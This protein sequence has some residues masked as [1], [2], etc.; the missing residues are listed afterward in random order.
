MM[1][2]TPFKSIFGMNN[3]L[4]G[5]PNDLTHTQIWDMSYGST[6]RC[7]TFEATNGPF[8]MDNLIAT[9]QTPKEQDS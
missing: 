6:T 1:I 5:I 8:I 2:F 4:W 9:P 7:Q 3:P